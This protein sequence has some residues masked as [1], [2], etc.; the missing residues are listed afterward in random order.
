LA[1]VSDR[2]P[3]VFD[4]ILSEEV[5][6]KT[7]S[8]PLSNNW[9]WSM[10]E[11]IDKSFT[12]KNSQFTKGAN[13]F[14]RPF[15]N[16]I[17]PIANVNYRTE[18]FDVKDVEVFVNSKE[19]FHKSFLTRKFHTKWAKKWSID[20]AIDESVESYFDYGLVLVKNVNDKRPEIVQL[21]QLAFCDPTDI[22]AGA[23]CLKHQFS[24]SDMLAMKGKWD[25]DAV[26]R[27]INHARFSQQRVDEKETRTPSKY[28]EVYELHGTFP[29]EWLGEGELSTDGGSYSPQ[30]HIVT[31]YVSP[32]TNE[33][34][35]IALFKGKEPKPIFK[36]LKRDSIY[37]RACGRG[38]IE[39]LFH[40]Q[41]WTNYSEIHLQQILE[42]VSKVVLKTTDSSFSKNN[43]TKNLKHG[44]VLKVADGKDVEQ[45]Q[46]TA[47]NYV[48]FEKNYLKWEQEA[49]AIGS[50]SDPQLG[51]NPTSG[52]PL[53]TTEI[54]T[55][56]GQGIHEYRRGKIAVFWGEIYRDWVLN[57]LVNDMLKG[58][59]WID[60]LSVDELREVAERVVTNEM[61][62]RIKE[63]IIGGKLI[64]K[65]EQE[66][67]RN[68]LK[69]AFTKQ[70]RKRF[71]KLVENELKDIPIDVDFNIAGKQAYQA[72][73]V[74][75]LNSVFRAVFANPQMLAN[76]AVAELFNNILESAG[77]SPINFAQ[78]NS[79]PVEQP[80][81]TEPQQDVAPVAV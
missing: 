53:G 9:D 71:L 61:N 62:Q 26:D 38:G 39:E 15:N 46:I 30:I 58:D 1:E 8:I 34:T 28:I 72:E 21:Q 76:D 55:A 77:L 29:D 14:S 65:E 42:A 57:Y 49:R 33:K 78:F 16:I 43:Q 12:L 36:A 56:Q 11:H 10:Y 19:D 47:P 3:D 25:E 68:V 6:F 79:Q 44:Q 31:Y 40:P 63:S 41:V 54:V 59:E 17:L 4:Y 35:G 80:Q 20:T 45:L 73:M 52:T 51:L 67:M 22:L 70:G 75:K 50:A 2:Y 5:A 66:E 23:I 81:P 18:G 64:T 60:E 27:A 7:R 32:E 24:I 48:L 74:N 69:E 37:G 13:D